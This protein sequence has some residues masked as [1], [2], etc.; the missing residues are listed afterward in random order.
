MILNGI[1]D[2]IYSIVDACST[3]REMW[4]AIEYLHQ[5]ESISKQ[6]VK[7]KLFWEFGKFTSRDGESIESYYSRFYKMMNE[8]VRNKLKVDT[9]QQ[10][11][12][13]VNEIRT[14]KIARNA[15][16]IALVAAAQQYLDRH[17]EEL[18]VT[19][20][21]LKKKRTRL[22]TY[23]NISQDYV[24]SSWRRCHNFY[25]TPSQRIIRRKLKWEKDYAY[26]KENMVMCKQEEKGV[27]LSTKHGEWLADTNNELDE[28]ELEAHYMYMEKIQEVPTAYSRPSYD[29]ETLEKV[30][31]ND[32]YN[33]FANDRQHSE[34]PE[35]IN[36]TYVV[37]KIDIYVILDSSYM[38]DN[39]GQAD[40][41]DIHVIPY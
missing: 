1:G 9:V 41:N 3:A 13:E 17:L 28:Q 31:S 39:E 8:M 18:R 16:L 33:V 14:K 12:N 6:D 5:G 38:C 37:E 21:D 29:A 10:H 25:V 30:H 2:G 40:Q 26:Y 15:N 35:S 7:T 20:A 22:R 36:E 24:L 34:Q 11:Q 4:L 19:W 23:T 32:D 27:P